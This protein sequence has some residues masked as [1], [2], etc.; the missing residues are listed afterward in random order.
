MES[1]VFIE[2]RDARLFSQELLAAGGSADVSEVGLVWSETGRLGG[3]TCSGSVVAVEDFVFARSAAALQLR[4]L[5]QG[6]H[7]DSTHRRRFWLD[8]QQQQSLVD[9]KHKVFVDRWT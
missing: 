5:F 8:T 1:L 3:C 7:L 9:N 4:R 2:R 6:V